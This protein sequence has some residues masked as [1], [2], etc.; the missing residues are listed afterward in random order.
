MLPEVLVAGEEL[1]AH[2]AAVLD[3]QMHAVLELHVR[4]VLLGDAERCV[5]LLARHLRQAFGHTPR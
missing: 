5:A 3:S 2:A 1:L 4:P